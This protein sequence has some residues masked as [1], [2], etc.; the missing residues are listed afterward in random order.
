MHPQSQITIIWISVQDDWLRLP[1]RR[2]VPSTHFS[3]A[4][5]YSYECVPKYTIMYYENK[6]AKP[7]S[8]IL[9]KSIRKGT[10]NIHRKCL[11]ARSD[12]SW[13]ISCLPV[14][15][16]LPPPPQDTHLSCKKEPYQP[17][18]ELCSFK[19]VNNML[20]L[21]ISSSI[22][23][24][25]IRRRERTEPCIQ[26][27]YIEIHIPKWLT[28]YQQCIPMLSGWLALAPPVLSGQTSTK[29]FE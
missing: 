4:R 17:L 3:V 7:L 29:H 26:Y 11:K 2:E 9:S 25:S 20:I 5:T 12:W 28:L 8:Q 21:R 15:V 1:W 10:V 23:T 19:N 16:S 18:L 27:E 13:P 14:P 22:L 24:F 6:S